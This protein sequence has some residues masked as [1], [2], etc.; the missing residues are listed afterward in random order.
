VKQLLK[1]FLYRIAPRRTTALMSA[2][3][4]AHSH[5]V[6]SGWGGKAVAEKLIERFGD[7]VQEGPFAGLKLTP[8]ACAE[9]VGPY[10]LGTYESELDG[11][12]GIVF[13]G[14][15]TQIVDI[16]AKFGY[17]AVG[18]AARYPEASVVAFDTDWWA[19]RAVTGM[20][21]ANGTRNV[22]VK[23]FCSPRWLGG[24]I[25]PASL[26]IS[27]C[28]GYEAALF[29]PSV[30]PALRSATLVIETHD[31][32]VPGVSENLRRVFGGTHLVRTFG[33]DGIRRGTTRAL[34]FLTDGERQLAI[35]EVR[36]PQI[37]L[38]CLPMTGP[39]QSL[40]SIA[41]P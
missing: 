10:L 35:Q 5:R 25:Q 33:H 1:A 2:R 21:A 34:D 7:R 3:A 16:G 29:G 40:R 15:Y 6:V 27:D 41:K 24:H 37:W 13:R 20:A 18:L 26:I 31:Q 22:E 12:W 4:R 11:A 8:A 32:M 30:I 28:E 39:N 38:L 9:Q 19:R 17:Y 14:S 23:G 36:S